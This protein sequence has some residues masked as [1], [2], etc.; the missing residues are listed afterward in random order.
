M[1]M[2]GMIL[3]AIF[4]EECGG[5]LLLQPLQ[6]CLA[7]GLRPRWGGEGRE[8]LVK[9]PDTEESG[10]GRGRPRRGAPAG[11]GGRGWRGRQLIR[12]VCKGLWPMVQLSPHGFAACSQA[13]TFPSPCVVLRG[14]CAHTPSTCHATPGLCLKCPCVWP[15]HQE[16]QPGAP[17]PPQGH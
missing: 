5:R 4:C 9:G 17:M 2:K 7:G 14:E 6:F 16:A 11:R 8:L 15:L 3:F 13:H 12:R 1:A 10:A